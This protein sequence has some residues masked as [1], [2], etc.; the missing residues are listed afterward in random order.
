MTQQFSGYPTFQH[1]YIGTLFTENGIDNAAW[2]YGLN[3]ATFPTY[4]GEVVQILSVYIDSLTLTGTV[5]T[6]AQMEQIYR[7]FSRFLQIETQG[8]NSTSSNNDGSTTGGAYNMVPI[9]FTYGVRN[10]KFSIIPMTVPGFH[11]GYDVIAP[12]WEI[13]CFVVDNSPD[14]GAIKSGIKALAISQGQM[15]QQSGTI[16]VD[17]NGG[18]STNVNS[19][20]LTGNISPNYADPNTD[21]FQTF[22]QGAQAAQSMVATYSSY[23]SS[24]IPSYNA[25]DFSTVTG[26]FGSSP[27]FGQTSSGPSAQK[28]NT[29]E[30]PSGNSARAKTS[31][32]NG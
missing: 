3:T 32:N 28:N 13:Q 30:K 25:N 6:Y 29:V 10:W 20:G 15:A 7:Y 27:N 21:P 9:K 1:P 26:E 4:A 12:T 19:F 23:Y 11:L 14:L 31:G 2:A 22:D 17:S 18:I 16:N 24:L 5:A 8:T